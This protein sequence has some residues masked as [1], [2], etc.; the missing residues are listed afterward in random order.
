VIDCAAPAPAYWPNGGQIVLTLSVTGLTG[1]PTFQKLVS[2]DG[3]TYM[4]GPFPVP[5]ASETTTTTTT[6]LKQPCKC[7][8][9]LA[10]AFDFG[11]A[12]EGDPFAP[13]GGPVIMVFRVRWTLTC[14]RG[15]GGCAATLD[16]VPPPGH[17]ARVA[18]SQTQIRNCR[19][20]PVHFKTPKP[21]VSKII[22]TGKCGEAVVGVAL[23]RIVADD[24]LDAA[25]IANSDVT[26]TLRRTCQ[27]KQLRRQL[28]IF[29]FGPHARFEP[30]KSLL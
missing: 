12:H 19:T 28:F 26:F 18:I 23:V 29:H 8:H 9:L 25:H 17:H 1:T 10:H 21:G 20:C 27:D 5:H 30:K 6:N 7:I 3:V 15:H 22:C 4:G 24:T 16:V 14:T 2:Y 11:F 13:P